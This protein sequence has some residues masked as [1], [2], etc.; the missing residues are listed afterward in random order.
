MTEQHSDW[1]IMQ[2]SYKD[3]NQLPTERASLLLEGQQDIAGLAINPPI[4]NRAE[5]SIK[6]LR[7]MFECFAAKKNG[8]WSIIN[9]DPLDKRRLAPQEAISTIISATNSSVWHTGD[10][11]LLIDSPSSNIL[12]QPEADG[13]LIALYATGSSADTMLQDV[14][15]QLHDHSVEMGL[16]KPDIEVH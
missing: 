9:K 12:I 1:V 6:I 3:A 8:S 11:S 5:S 13:A 14:T 4:T 15:K 2:T 10:I 16:P 7:Q